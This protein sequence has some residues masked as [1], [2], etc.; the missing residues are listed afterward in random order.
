M[1][2]LGWM[3]RTARSSWHPGSHATRTIQSDAPVPRWSNLMT[4]YP[5]A[6]RPEEFGRPQDRIAP[7]GDEQEDR[8][9]FPADRRNRLLPDTDAARIR[10]A[11]GAHDHALQIAGRDP[12]DHG[13]DPR[14]KARAAESEPRGEGRRAGEETADDGRRGGGEPGAPCAHA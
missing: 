12:V 5:A 7:E 13:V 8:A 3:P 10:L 4:R 1:S 11:G 14:R 6:Q 2:E 9:A